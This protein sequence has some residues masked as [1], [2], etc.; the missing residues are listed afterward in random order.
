MKALEHFYAVVRTRNY[1]HLEFISIHATFDGARA[2]ADEQVASCKRVSKTL[3]AP[4]Q[5]TSFLVVEVPVIY[6]AQWRME[7]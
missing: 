2:A 3:P 7:E 4:I 6:I 5:T 1:V